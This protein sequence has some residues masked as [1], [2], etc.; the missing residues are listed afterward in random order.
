MAIYKIVHFVTRNASSQNYTV[1]LPNK[2]KGVATFALHP[3]HVFCLFIF[4][5]NYSFSLPCPLV[6][7]FSLLP[8]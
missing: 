8:S 1:I 5:K 3:S 2:P 7:L 4:P 6:S